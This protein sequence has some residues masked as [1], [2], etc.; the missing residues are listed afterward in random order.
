MPSFMVGKSYFGNFGVGIVS[1]INGR[2]TLGAKCGGGNFAVANG[3]GVRGGS[4]VLVAE[5][6]RSGLGR[7]NRALVFSFVVVWF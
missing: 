7:F 2:Y 6:N 4:C 1:V 5:K 3:D